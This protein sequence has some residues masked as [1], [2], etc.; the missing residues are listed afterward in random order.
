LDALAFA[1]ISTIKSASK[2]TINMP[3]NHDQTN[4]Q[5]GPIVATGSDS[6]TY[7]QNRE[8]VLRISTL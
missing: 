4:V 7:G 3:F 5:N 2:P 8:F 6:H 1:P